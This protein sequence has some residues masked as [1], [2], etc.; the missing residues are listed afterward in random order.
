MN[1]IDPGIKNHKWKLKSLEEQIHTSK[2]FIPFFALTKTH[3]KSYH[4]DAEVSV[5]D[6]TI[7]RA[8]RSN[9]I[10][11]GVAIFV[12]NK[13]PVTRQFS[14]SNSY[15]EAAMVYLSDLNMIISAVYRPPRCPENHFQQC[16]AEITKF[17][18]CI[19]S[20]EIMIVGDFNFPF[21][22]WENNNLTNGHRLHSET[23]SAEILLNFADENFLFQ[24]VEETTR[25]EKSVLDLIFTNNPDAIHSVKIEK[26]KASDHDIVHA[27]LNYTGLEKSDETQNTL[28]ND[29]AFDDLNFTKAQWDSIREEL[30]NIDW[31]SFY[32]EEDPVKLSEL[33]EST[34]VEAC[35]KHTPSHSAGKTSKSNIPPN[36]RSLLRKK[37]RLNSRINCLKYKSLNPCPTKISE[38]NEQK[39]MIEIKIRDSIKEE[40]ILEENKAIE[41]IKTNAK[42]FYSYAKRTCKTK[43]PVGPLQDNDGKLQNDPEIMANLL[44]DQYSKV[45]SNPSEVSINDVQDHLDLDTSVIDDIDFTEDDIIGAINNMPLHSAS[46]PDKFPSSVLKE[47]KNQLSSPIHHLWRK[48][49]DKSSIPTEYLQQTIVPIY[50]KG[51]RSLAS[52]YRPVSLTSHIIKV[53]ER[54]MRQKLVNHIEEN[55]LLVNQQHGFR[56]KRN[57]LTQLLHHVEEIIQALENDTNADVIYLDFSKA[58]DK[59]D[60]KVLLHKLSKMGIR[61]KLLS[62]ISSFLSNR[63]QRVIIKG[64]KSRPTLVIS[65]VPQGTVLGPLLFI[66]YINDITEVVKN[67]SIKIFADDSKLQHNISTSE[68][69][70]KLQADLVAVID[71][72]KANNME[73]NESKFELIHYGYND[74]LKDVYTL[75]S[76]INITPSSTVR[77]LGILMDN[78]LNFADHYQKMI[79]EAKKYAGWILRTF[80]NRSKHVILLLYGSFVRSRLEYSCPL[81]LPHTKKTIM[82]IESVQR[83]I[84]AKIQQ[85]SHLNYWDRLQKL[86]LYS[87]QRRRERYCIIHVWKIL[88]DLAP[89]DIRMTFQYNPRLGPRAELPKLNAKRQHVNTLRDQSF[90]CMGPRLFNL[91][92]KDLKNLDSLPLFKSSLDTFLKSFPDTPPT[93]GY[94]AANGNSVIDWVA[95]G[96][97]YTHKYNGDTTRGGATTLVMA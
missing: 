39:A 91:L 73:L 8:D 20:P 40:K 35:K 29:S 34:V 25:A 84:T 85:V 60:H 18:S 37:K 52:N 10:K 55:H 53:F 33:L 16:L 45:F 1:G 70:E 66:I 94:V 46:G 41:R 30:V 95:C 43:D 13:F 80:T 62:W 63:Q 54:V 23:K 44:Q 97:P 74:S 76:G 4:F 68:D 22:N 81:W 58:F 12:H 26:T 32:N 72:A 78:K 88:K 6:Y 77:D 75:P 89:N 9:R 3:L 51:D 86:K 11:G 36:R 31:T 69:R 21:I 2:S 57:C 14:Y 83:T 96:S 56:Q 5:K 15:C 38:L 65:G 64:S 42:A 90:S 71:W 17:I 59:V 67:S 49:L 48:S 93:P 50:K 61:G 79:K 92:P 47:C 7:Y 24:V 82:Q 87:L 27:S 19:D 28:P